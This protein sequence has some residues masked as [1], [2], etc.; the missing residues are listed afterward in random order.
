MERSS[1]RNK[2]VCIQCGCVEDIDYAV[3]RSME[4]FQLLF[5]E[6]KIT[7]NGVYEWCGEYI[8]KT[9]RRILMKNFNLMNHSKHSYFVDT[10]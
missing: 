6:Q 2:L 9:I 8:K 4:E 7:S 3:M 5:Q 10:K 1:V